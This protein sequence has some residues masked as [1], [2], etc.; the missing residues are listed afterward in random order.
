ME[1]ESEESQDTEHPRGLR[2]ARREEWG[3]ESASGN[4]RMMQHGK[5]K[6]DFGYTPKSLHS[7]QGGKG[8]HMSPRK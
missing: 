7:E 8:C 2:P 3:L 4:P 6:Q 5:L 1:G